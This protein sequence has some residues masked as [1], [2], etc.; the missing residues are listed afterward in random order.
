MSSPSG[1][2]LDFPLPEELSVRK[3]GGIMMT[4][5][6]DAKIK[7]IFDECHERYKAIM[8]EGRKNGHVKDPKREKG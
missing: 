1:K 5:S 7:K 2:L 8:A 6:V 3:F 4:P